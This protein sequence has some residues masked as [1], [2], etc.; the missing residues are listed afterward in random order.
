MQRNF[1]EGALL[2]PQFSESQA[3]MDMGLTLIQAKVY[4]A[5]VESGPSKTSVI[6]KIS[7]VAQPDVYKT[8]SK[9]RKLGLVE[10][11]I[12][13]PHEYRAIPINDGVSFLLE[14]K[15]KQFEKVRAEARLLLREVKMKKPT[16][17]KKTEEAQFVLIP[18]GKTV[19]EKINTAIAN[20]KISVDVLLSWKRF[21]RGLAS[22]FA[23]SIEIAWAKNVKVRFI[24]EKPPKSK[25]AEQ[26]VQFC[27]E[28]HFC[29]MRFIPYYPQIILGIYDKKEVFLIVKPKTD[30]PGSPAL[31]SNNHSLIALAEDHFEVLWLVAM[32]N[33]LQSLWKSKK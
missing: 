24:V 15:R 4:L 33:S 30:L 16:E 22:T 25:T 23:E 12:K 1:S 19:I 7:K 11:I 21:S 3:L 32:E 20:A 2:E 8:L 5:L 10:E 31:W 14:T 18:E 13:T 17:K 26:L 6:S 27:R 28:K 29:Q 9:L